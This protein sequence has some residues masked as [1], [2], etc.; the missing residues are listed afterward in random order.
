MVIQ[1]ALLT[2]V[3]EQLVPV[4]TDTLPLVL[5][6]GANVELAGDRV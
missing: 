3:Q 1:A 4:V 6:V 5:A 2:A